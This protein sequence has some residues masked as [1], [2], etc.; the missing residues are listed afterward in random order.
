M[1]A[2][3]KNV[4]MNIFQS[5][6]KLSIYNINK[7][8]I[9]KFVY[10]TLNNVPPKCFSEYYRSI[11][12]VHTHNTRSSNKLF[13]QQFRTNMRKMFLINE[14]TNIWNLIPQNI[15]MSKSQSEFTK[16]FKSYLMQNNK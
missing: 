3:N 16:H 2:A 7:L 12:N 5:G 14:G 15:K 9:A 4:G 11:S 13:V 10:A 6:K 8:Q 1:Y